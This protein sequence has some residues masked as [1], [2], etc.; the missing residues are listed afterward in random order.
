M[1]NNTKLILFVG[2]LTSSLLVYSANCGK[3]EGHKIVTYGGLSCVVAKK[4]F[5]SF[6]AGKIPKGWNCGQSVGGCG[7]RNKGFTFK[8]K[9][10]SERHQT[11]K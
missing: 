5:V 11:F 9:N 3:V 2:L 7:N 4:I 1:M 8:L 6:Q 10:F